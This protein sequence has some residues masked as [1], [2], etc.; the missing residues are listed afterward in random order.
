MRNY[1]TPG[2][3]YVVPLPYGSGYRHYED[4]LARAIRYADIVA[5]TECKGPCGAEVYDYD[6]ETMKPGCEPVYRITR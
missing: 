4:E 2:R 3:Y 6:E 5:Y 1:L